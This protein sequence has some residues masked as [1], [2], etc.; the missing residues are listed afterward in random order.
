[1]FLLWFKL[2]IHGFIAWFYAIFC[3]FY[4]ICSSTTLNTNT[5]DHFR[6]ER[7]LEAAW[8]ARARGRLEC[9]SSYWLEAQRSLCLH[10]VRILTQPPSLKGNFVYF[11]DLKG[12]KKV[13][14]GRKLTKYCGKT[15]FRYLF[16][17]QWWNSVSLLF[18]IAGHQHQGWCRRH[19][20]SSIQHLS[21][22]PDWG[23][24]IP[25]PDS[26]AFDKCAQRY[27]EYWR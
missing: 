1:M 25:V 26:P 8:G 24:L 15:K 11:N 7:M 17:P 27:H 20:Y 12:W 13:Q 10:K 22:V 14:N 5:V 6:T 21:P 23:T 4:L 18:H 16:Y 3:Y 2:F 19:Q 9:G